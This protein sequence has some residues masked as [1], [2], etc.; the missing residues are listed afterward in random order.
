LSNRFREKLADTLKEIKRS[1]RFGEYE[2]NE[3]S[4]SWEIRGRKPD[5]TVSVQNQPFL[6]I[7]CKRAI[8]HSPWDDFPIGQAYTYALLAKKEGYSVDFIATAN[9]YYMAIFRVPEN[10][11]DYANWEA[12]KYEIILTFFPDFR[13]TYP[14]L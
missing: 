3:V 14:Y 1:Y 5:M 8:E 13:Y 7:E 2:I 4:T 12:I 10:L 11:E 9:Q 6:I